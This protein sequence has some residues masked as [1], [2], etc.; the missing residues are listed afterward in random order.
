MSLIK[1]RRDGL[2]LLLLGNAIFLLLGLALEFHSPFGMEDFKAVYYGARSLIQHHDPYQESELRAVYR[3]DGGTFP[4]NSTNSRSVHDAISIC[5][6]LPTTLFLVAPLAI[7]PWGAAAALWMVLTAGS[8]MLA[9][10]LMWSLGARYTPRVSGGLVFLVIANSELLLIVGNAAG[11][12]ISLCVVAVWCFLQERFALAGVL[13]LAFSL[14][15]KPHDAVLVCLYFLL[16]GGVHR[17]HALQSLVVAAGLSL[18]AI[19]W[20]SHVAP[21]WMAELHSNLEATS[22]RG[23]L[24]DPGPAS[25][26]SHGLGMVISLQAVFS[27][28]RD[29]PHFYNSFS[30]LVCG[31][32]LLAWVAVILRSRSSPTREWLALASIAAL[33]MLP[34]Y[35]RSY[36]ARLLLLTVPACAQL[37]SKGVTIARFALLV[38][39][40]GVVMTGDLTWAFILSIINNL[41]LSTAGFCGQILTF[42]QVIPAPVT[43]LMLAIFYLSVYM[44]GVRSTGSTR[45]QEDQGRTPLPPAA[46]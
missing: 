29:D 34:V 9:G 8:L 15:I 40:A 45:Q 22:A 30:Y 16:A 31:V 20:A 19:L 27:L 1:A 26:G 10:F 5:I 36:D 44:R 37:W 4:S 11:I 35:H 33:T 28:F 38:N 13:C 6:N 12:A 46:T 24:N 39:A 42:V 14:A 21:H 17:K 3:A 32:L 2:Y 41:H 7:L 18:P 25:M 43:L 23:A